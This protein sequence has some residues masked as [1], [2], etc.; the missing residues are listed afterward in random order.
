ML[1]GAINY[2]QNI[3]IWFTD[4]LTRTYRA[5]KNCNRLNFDASS[6][7]LSNVVTASEMFMD[8]LALTGTAA[9]GPSTGFDSLVLS[10]LRFG[11]R[12]FKGTL[13]NPDVGGWFPAPSVLENADGMF[14]YNSQFVGT[15]IDQWD[16]SSIEDM[17]YMFRDCRAFVGTNIGQTW[18]TSNVGAANADGGMAYMFQ[19]TLINEEFDLWDYSNVNTIEGMFFGCKNLGTSID[20]KTRYILD[21]TNP[22]KATKVT[23]LDN[24]FSYCDNFNEDLTSWVLGI[25]SKML[26]H[27]TK[28]LLTGMLVTVIDLN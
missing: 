15:N 8:C 2:N 23:T 16:T 25:C 11:A 1:Y 3:G 28:I 12:M 6:W 9:A 13:V 19:N 10:S 4:N 20:N 17:N 24:L 21:S 14:E 5:F 26:L 18:D 22:N 7:T 27:L